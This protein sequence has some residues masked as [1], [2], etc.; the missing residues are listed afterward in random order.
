M[1]IDRTVKI[2]L[3]IA[4][5]VFLTTSFILKI[6]TIYFFYCTTR[7][8]GILFWR[9]FHTKKKL[10]QKSLSIR[11][12][13]DKIEKLKSVKVYRFFFCGEKQRIFIWQ[14]SFVYFFLADRA[15]GKLRRIAAATESIEYP[16]CSAQHRLNSGEKRVWKLIIISFL[17]LTR[18]RA[19]VI[20]NNNNFFLRGSCFFN[21]FNQP[22]SSKTRQ[23]KIK[24]KSL[25]NL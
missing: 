7:G 8:L 19:L 13:A 21:Y 2:C 15:K 10:L 14:F 6:I 16:S 20:K 25:F 18:S 11:S 3:W 24:R 12:K 9:R 5:D 1:L 22:S 17:S 4:Y 23:R